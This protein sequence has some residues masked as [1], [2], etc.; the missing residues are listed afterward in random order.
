MT[1]NRSLRFW[2][3]VILSFGVWLACMLLGGAH[4]E[5]DESAHRALYAGGNAVL[6][7]NAL[8]LTSLGEGF[9]LS[10]LALL[11]FFYLFFR[12][13]VRSAL[14]LIIIFG[15]RLMVELQKAV[16][17]RPRPGVDPH[18]EAVTSLSFPSGHSANSMITYL[19]IALLV[20]V[21]QRNRAISVGIGLALAVQVGWSRVALGVHWPTDVLGGWSFGI[22][23]IAVCMRLAH[24]RTG[25]EA[26]P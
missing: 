7:R 14:L 9:V 6:T 23:W 17:G 19:A 8:F 21:K 24:V 20:P 12:R 11:A 16:V 1:A 25:G 3:A 10:G 15:G 4:T 26:T 2:T 18:L 5:F 22:L 13:K